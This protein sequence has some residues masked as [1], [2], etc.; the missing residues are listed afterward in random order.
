MGNNERPN[1]YLTTNIVELSKKN[2]NSI[3]EILSSKST[4]NISKETR[5]ILIIIKFYMFNATLYETIRLR[6]N[7][8]HLIA[9]FKNDLTDKT[10]LNAAL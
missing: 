10:I 4:P 3:V 6:T 5:E 1:I 8:I 7:I 9:S 2:C